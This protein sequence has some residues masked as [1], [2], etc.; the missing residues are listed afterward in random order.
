MEFLWEVV[1]NFYWI[2][3]ILFHALYVDIYLIFIGIGGVSMGISW[4]LWDV[5]EISSDITRNL[6]GFTGFYWHVNDG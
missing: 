2:F 6:R 3:C 4:N 1:G 5:M